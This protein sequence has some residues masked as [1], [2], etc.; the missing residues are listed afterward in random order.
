MS[1]REEIEAVRSDVLRELMFADR[2]LAV[3]LDGWAGCLR[4]ALEGLDTRVERRTD[5]R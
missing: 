5:E 4:R 3:K 2:R 1:P